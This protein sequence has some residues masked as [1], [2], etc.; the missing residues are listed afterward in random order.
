MPICEIN[1]LWSRRPVPSELGRIGSSLT[2]LLPSEFAIQ[3][4]WR[5]FQRKKTACRQ[6]IPPIRKR[7]PVQLHGLHSRQIVLPNL[8]SASAGRIVVNRLAIPRLGRSS[9]FEFVL[10]Q[11]FGSPPATAIV[12]TAEW[13]SGRAPKT[14]DFPWGDQRIVPS[15]GSAKCVT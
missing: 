6:A 13:P 7:P 5:P 2:A 3:R 8:R 10:L 15:H 14:I 1:I 9:H 12:K 11:G 4:A